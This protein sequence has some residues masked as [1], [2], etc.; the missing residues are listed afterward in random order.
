MNSA[1]HTI[2]TE[3]ECGMSPVLSTSCFARFD[4]TMSFPSSF[5]QEDASD[6]PKAGSA[7][8][9]GDTKTRERSVL[10]EVTILGQFEKETDMK[11]T[12]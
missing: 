1:G 5:R 2:H 8:L 7:G 9:R 11:S 6:L 4:Q 10:S 12:I 3:S